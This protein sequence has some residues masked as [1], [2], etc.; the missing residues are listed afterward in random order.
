M[1]D[2][3]TSSD[4]SDAS[5]ESDASPA[6]GYIYVIWPQ[7]AIRD[8][9]QVFKVGRSN[10]VHKRLTG[11]GR[12]SEILLSLPVYNPVSTETAL[13]Q[14]LT[15]CPV[16]QQ[17]LDFGNEYFTSS[18]GHPDLILHVLIFLNSLNVLLPTMDNKN[19]LEGIGNLHNSKLAR[20]SLKKKSKKCRIKIRPPKHSTQETSESDSPVLFT[21]ATNSTS[22][23]QNVSGQENEVPISTEKAMLEFFPN[24]WDALRDYQQLHQTDAV[25]VT[26]VKEMFDKWALTRYT[27]DTSTGTAPV[28]AMLKRATV[29]MLCRFMT[30]T[31][32]IKKE[33]YTFP[34]MTPVQQFGIKY[35]TISKDQPG[36]T[37]GEETLE[38]SKNPEAFIKKQLAAFLSADDKSR[39]CTITRETGK[40][41][42]IE[43]FTDAF[44][45]YLE[46]HDKGFVQCLRLHQYKDVLLAH[47]FSLAKKQGHR[48]N[49]CMQCKQIGSTG[50]KKTA[51]CGHFDYDKGR[52][53]KPV[54]YNMVL[55]RS[56][57]MVVMGYR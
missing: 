20:S 32:G 47:G 25:P 23:S 38:T 37:E 18:R 40:V 10:N 44:N 7:A 6:T 16:F 52:T 57:K 8:N 13:L 11:Y 14:Y 55:N 2:L 26:V 43:D 51:C 28:H 27:Q 4:S 24:N 21:T 39:G 31:Y 34:N 30:N 35:N 22:T 49:V 48:E 9:K 41:T 33:L 5:I 45:G 19:F 46:R 50:K 3:H 53:T 1:N 54:I 15:S 29:S 56:A 12:F 17:A 36:E 42:W